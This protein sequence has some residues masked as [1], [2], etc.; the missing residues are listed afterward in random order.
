MLRPAQRRTPIQN[1]TEIAAAHATTVAEYLSAY[2]QC[3]TL[4]D[5]A[6]ADLERFDAE[7][8]AALKALAAAPVRT[9]ADIKAKAAAVAREE[10]MDAA[11]HPLV[12]AVRFSLW[13]DIAELAP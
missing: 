3:A 10:G 11:E 2:R 6:S 1:A 12:A 7:R 4:A 9:L 13:Q 5:E 8:D